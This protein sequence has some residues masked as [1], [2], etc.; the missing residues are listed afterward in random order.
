MLK[1]IQIMEYRIT[2]N[3]GKA[4]YVVSYHICKLHEDG[5]KF[6]DIAIFSNK[7]NMNLFVRQLK[8]ITNV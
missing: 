4:K 3:V 2:H 1:K 6:F 7:K 5:S 8:T